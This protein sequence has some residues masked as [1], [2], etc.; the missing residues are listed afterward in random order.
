MTHLF[1][2]RTYG[3][4]GCGVSLL[5]LFSHV[6][7]EGNLCVIASLQE[8]KMLNQINNFRNDALRKSASTR[9]SLVT[10]V[11]RHQGAV[12]FI[13]RDDGMV[14]IGYSVNAHRRAEEIRQISAFDARLVALVAAPPRRKR[15]LHDRFAVEHSGR[16]WFV[17]SRRLVRFM[18]RHL[19][20]HLV[21]ITP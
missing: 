9:H 18:S 2:A 7:C 15:Q 1:I 8:N 13:V 17:M 3:H 20:V 19:G 11:I 4:A 21:V 12:Y 5:K 6:T 16:G 10:P 14:K